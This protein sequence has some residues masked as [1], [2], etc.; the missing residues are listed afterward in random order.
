MTNGVAKWRAKNRVRVGLSTTYPLHIDGIR[1][2]PMCGTVERRFVFTVGPQN[3]I[4]PHGE[5]YPRNAVIITKSK[6]VTPMFQVFCR[7]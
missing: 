4:S 5:T 3:L 6:R 2:V 7:R 1:E